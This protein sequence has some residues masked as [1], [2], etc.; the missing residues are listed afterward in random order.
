[1]LINIKTSLFAYQ[2]Q[3]SLITIYV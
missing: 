3:F 2:S 1:M